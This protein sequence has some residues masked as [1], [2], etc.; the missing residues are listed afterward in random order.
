MPSLVDEAAV[1][2]SPLDDGSSPSTMT[3]ASSPSR[4]SDSQAA[5]PSKPHHKILYAE[6]KDWAPKKDIICFHYV[7]ERRTLKEVI[8]IMLYEHGFRAKY[9]I[10][11]ISG[12]LPTF[13]IS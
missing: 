12:A 10:L 4:S 13:A 3:L 7:Q 9:D 6:P 11:S 1:S 8:K 5:S 2:S